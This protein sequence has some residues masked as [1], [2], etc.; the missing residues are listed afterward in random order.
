MKLFGLEIR[1]AQ[2]PVKDA[3]TRM[4]E[5]VDALNAAWKDLRAQGELR[6]RP[7]VIWEENRV[8]VSERAEQRLKVF[9]E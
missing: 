7:W 4:C 9:H 1:K 8:V 5:A 3:T 6:L 2:P